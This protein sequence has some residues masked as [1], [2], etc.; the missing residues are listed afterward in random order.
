MYL[1]GLTGGIA[2]GKSTVADLLQDLG[3]EV[4]DADQVAREVVLPGTAGLEAV[5]A[6]FGKSILD[7]NGQLSRAKL[8][9]IVFADPRKR[10]KLESIIH[11]IIQ[12]R[13]QELI[14]KSNKDVV[15]YAVPLL[16]EAKV[17]YP[18]DFVVTVEAGVKTQLDRLLR[19]RGMSESEARARIAAQTSESERVQRAD[20]RLDSSGSLE[21]LKLQ[22]EV[23]WEEIQER[24]ATQGRNGAN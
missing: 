10:E 8:A 17:S 5:V 14:S 11:P 16:V 3:A 7:E 18:F 24:M 12:K 19:T 4:I 22:V 20:F 6:E 1:I 15:V 23:L 2:S 13:T 9:G 21:D